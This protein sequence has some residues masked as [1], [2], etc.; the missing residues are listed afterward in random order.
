MD[1]LVN[2]TGAKISILSDQSLLR[3]ATRL[4]SSW[5]GVYVDQPDRPPPPPRDALTLSVKFFEFTI[6]NQKA[7]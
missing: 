1:T 2:S 3:L 5:L 7:S 6:V 4:L